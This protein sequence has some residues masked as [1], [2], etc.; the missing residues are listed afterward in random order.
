VG[1]TSMDQ[2]KNAMEVN[3]FG[4]LR[5]IKALLPS[6]K[7]KRGRIVNVSSIAGRFSTIGYGP[8]AGI[9]HPPRRKRKEGRGMNDAQRYI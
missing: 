6:L 7:K 3:Y 4:P 2:I 5:L 9:D 1:L 8:Y